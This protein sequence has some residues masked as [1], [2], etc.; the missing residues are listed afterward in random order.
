VSIILYRS[1][2]KEQKDF[3][4]N[5]LT[6]SFEEIKNAVYYG[7][8]KP[9]LNKGKSFLK[10]A[11]R[12]NIEIFAFLLSSL[13]YKK[14]QIDFGEVLSII[15]RKN[16]IELLEYILGNTKDLS[17]CFYLDK[18]EYIKK[19]LYNTLCNNECSMEIL[20]L[21]FEKDHMKSYNFDTEGKNNIIAKIIKEN[22]YSLFFKIIKD[23]TEYDYL[24]RLRINERL[25]KK[26]NIAFL[27]EYLN[28]CDDK[29]EIKDLLLSAAKSGNYEV[30]SKY[31]NKNKISL[32][33]INEDSS[34]LSMAL[35]TKNYKTIKKFYDR[36]ITTLKIKAESFNEVPLLCEG[37]L[38]KQVFNLFLKDKSFNIN[39]N[40]NK[41]IQNALLRENIECIELI[42]T[43]TSNYI[44]PDN[45]MFYAIFND[46]IFNLII[47]D[48]RF[49]YDDETLSAVKSCITYKKISKLKIL[50]TSEEINKKIDFDLLVKTFN[51]GRYE[52]VRELLRYKK[53]ASFKNLPMKKKMK[54]FC[55]I[56]QF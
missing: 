25:I 21:L 31:V 14:S 47:K 50:L 17:F 46:D 53:Y 12:G 26:E 40:K 24:L 20:K 6:L 7:Y 33:V 43:N 19:A 23:F 8:A 13:G 51:E 27:T 54:L 32:K 56:N 10:A 9:H 2:Y 30:L 37:K 1:A 52:A 35:A 55:K 49:K 11:E 38:L 34:L 42:L 3:E 28:V 39:E 48:N 22:E 16:N 44:F 15:V 36:K 41:I 5:I 4:N 29:A 18:G 45:C